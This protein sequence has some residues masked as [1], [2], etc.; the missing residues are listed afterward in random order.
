M[1]LTQDI[2]RQ[3]IK[4]ALTQTEIEEKADS[5]F[6]MLNNLKGQEKSVLSLVNQKLADAATTNERKLTPAEEEK[7]EEIAQA[8]EEEDP[9][10]DMGDKMAMATAQAKKSA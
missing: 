10:I 7:R 6:A 4:E 3:L 9:D 1:K 8:M 5:I 2:I